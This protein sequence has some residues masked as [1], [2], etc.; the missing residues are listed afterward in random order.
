VSG[1]AMS[2][3]SALEFRRVVYFSV[4]RKCI[5]S[6]TFFERRMICHIPNPIIAI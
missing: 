3:T 5:Y 6:H 1:I 4:F 2:W